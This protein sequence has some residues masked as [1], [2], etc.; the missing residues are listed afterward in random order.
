M[1][2]YLQ[3]EKT[4]RFIMKLNDLIENGLKSYCNHVNRILTGV[5]AQINI[6]ITIKILYL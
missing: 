3:T 1:S 5:P 2:A 6:Y 4:K